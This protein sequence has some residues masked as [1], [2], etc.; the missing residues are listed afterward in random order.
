MVSCCALLLSYVC[1]HQRYADTV[2]LSTLTQW[3]FVTS[4]VGKSFANVANR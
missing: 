4:P 1:E 3:I 2:L